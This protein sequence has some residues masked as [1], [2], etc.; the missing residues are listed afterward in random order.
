[1]QTTYHLSSAEDVPNIVE[2]IISAY[3]SKAVTITVEDDS[4]AF[5]LTDV[6]KDTL[7]ERLMEDEGGYLTA[8]QSITQLKSKYGV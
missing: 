8:E 3:K 4:D 2:S 6:M 5:E 7:D 1:M